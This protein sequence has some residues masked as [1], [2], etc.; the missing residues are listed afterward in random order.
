MSQSLKLLKRA[1]SLDGLTQS[2]REKAFS[3]GIRGD[4]SRFGEHASLAD[5]LASRSQ[6][7]FNEALATMDAEDEVYLEEISLLKEDI[8]HLDT[9]LA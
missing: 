6:K 9:L 7:I 2:S 3:Y 1:V 8:E 5:F 4:I